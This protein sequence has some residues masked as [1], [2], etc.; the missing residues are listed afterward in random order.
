ML[1]SQ[2]AEYIEAIGKMSAGSAL[3]FEDVTWDDY[4]ELLRE[5]S[6]NSHYRISYDK[7]RLEIMSP[8]ERHEYRKSILGSLVEILTEELDMGLVRLGST[9]W[10]KKKN[11]QGAE[12]DESFYITNCELIR[13]K[14]EI[15][16]NIHPPPDLV[17]EIDVSHYSQNKFDIYAGLGVPEFWRYRKGAIRFYGLV[18]GEY[19]EIATSGLFSFLKPSDL[20]S[21]MNQ[22][23]IEEFNQTK[24]A[25]RE[26]VRKHK[27]AP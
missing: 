25:F 11:S 17:I 22:D 12:P 15:D 23:Y 7:G 14:R 1:T 26:W 24:R 8:S 16:L 10:K 18:E 6:D 3:I 4:E 27:S 9:T 5:F 2:A 13:N 21:Y 20:N 19:V